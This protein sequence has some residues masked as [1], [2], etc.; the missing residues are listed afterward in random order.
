MKKIRFLLLLLALTAASVCGCKQKDEKWQERSEYWTPV[1]KDGKFV[2]IDLN[3]EVIAKIDDPDVFGAEFAFRNGET[4]EV[5]ND[6]TLFGYVNKKGKMIV[7][8]VYNGTETFPDLVNHWKD[9]DVMLLPEWVD[10]LLPIERDGE[11]QY[12]N[13]DGEIVDTGTE[14]YDY[15]QIGEAGEIFEGLTLVSREYRKGFLNREREEVIPCIY[16]MPWIYSMGAPMGAPEGCVWVTRDEKWGCI[17]AEGKEVIPCIYD[18]MRGFSDGFAAV[19]KDG[20]W[21]YINESG[22]EV[23]PFIYDDAQDFSEGLAAVKKG[24]YWGYINEEGKNRVPYIWD[25]VSEYSEGLAKVQQGITGGYIDR[26]GFIAIPLE[27]SSH[28]IGDGGSQF[29]NGLAG[30]C[31]LTNG[32]IGFINSS[33]EEVIPCT[34]DNYFHSTG[35]INGVAALEKD[36]LQGCINEQGEVVIPFIYDDLWRNEEQGLIFVWKDD[37]RGCLDEQGNELI[38]PEYDEIVYIEEAERFAAKTKELITV[39]DRS[40]EEVFTW[41]GTFGAFDYFGENKEYIRVRDE[42]GLYGVIDWDGNVII[43]PQYYNYHEYLQK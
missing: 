26:H 41:E 1:Y 20:K 15:E 24:E 43:K 33:G 40:G 29:Q 36:E 8:C 34:Y 42:N 21:G 28:N 4:A 6:E 38:P 39:F 30:V 14:V 37:L 19:Q 12:I 9:S 32:K 2:I 11:L 22:E 18:D 25:Y 13:A 10:G 7:P 3:N 5:Y 23:I 17:N 31:S 16:D 27:Y 35:F